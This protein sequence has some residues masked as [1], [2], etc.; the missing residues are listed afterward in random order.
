[1]LVKQNF[2]GGVWKKDLSGVQQYFD[3]KGDF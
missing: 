3:K 1:M 2:L